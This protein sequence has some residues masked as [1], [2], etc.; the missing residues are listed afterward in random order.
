MEPVLSRITRDDVAQKA[1]VSSATVSRVY[2]RPGTVSPEKRDR[3]LSAAAVLGYEPN[4]HAS[5]LRRS[6]TGR[7]TLVEFTKPGRDYYWGNQPLLKW[8]YADVVRSLLDE[9][10]VSLFQIQMAGVDSVKDLEKLSGATDG[11]IGYDI[12]TQREIEML[13]STG[14]P[15]VA[16]HHT[17][18][19]PGLPRVSTDNFAGGRLQGKY[20]KNLGV[21]RPLYVTGY[22]SLVPAH[23]ERLK[24][25]LSVYSRKET[26]ILGNTA[27]MEAGKARSS[28]F[29]RLLTQGAFDGLAGVNDLTLLGLLSGSWK[30]NTPGLEKLPVVGYDNLPVLPVFPFPLATVD[31]RLNRI[32]REAFRLLLDL[33]REPNEQPPVSEGVTRANGNDPR[34]FASRVIQPVL[35]KPGAV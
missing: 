31:L 19:L 13:I 17:A 34:T 32:Y 21:K 8:M 2:N 14:L 10:A 25:F 5:S 15:C 26:Q 23:R 3:V 30:R 35:R 7:I 9:A 6:G 22:L 28:R 1:R 33:L 11:I 16:C 27:G 20:L 18:S 29:C 24:G 12:D 4:R